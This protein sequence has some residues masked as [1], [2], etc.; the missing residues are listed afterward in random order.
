MPEIPDLENVCAVLN[1]R[2]PGLTV[3]AVETP[4]PLVLRTPAA[5]FARR[6]RGATFK[7]V[8]RRGKFLLYRLAG[9]AVLA[10]NPMLV[11]RFQYVAPERK[12]PART[13]FVLGLSN[14][15][16]LR[17]VDERSMGKVYLVSE[18]ELAALPQLAGMGP[19]ALDPALTEEE[20]LRR[21]RR[22]RGAVKQVLV[23]AEFIAGIGNAYADEILFEAGIHPFTKVRD[24]GEEERRALQRAVPA[25]LRWAIAAVGEA[26]EEEIDRKPRAFLR[27]HRKGGQACPRCGTAISE[28][29][30]QRRVTSFCRR[31]QPSGDRA[32]PGGGRR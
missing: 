7:G 24:L 6:L 2:L 29:S 14:G 4:R 3:A 8:G 9:D 13:C 27:V 32:R 16:E 5:E 1:R 28:I 10:V 11:G 19:D 18:A 31:C 23:K 25:V 15:R 26:M 21:L 22:Y 17:Y 20:F 30:P 12:R